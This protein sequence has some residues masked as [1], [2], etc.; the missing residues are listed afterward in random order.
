MFDKC[1]S[2]YKCTDSQ[3]CFL[4]L[5]PFF[6]HLQYITY[7]ISFIFT[8]ELKCITGSVRLKKWKNEIFWYFFVTWFDYILVCI[9]WLCT[10]VHTCR[11]ERLHNGLHYVM[12][13][14]HGY[15]NIQ[16]NKYYVNVFSISDGSVRKKQRV[17]SALLY[18]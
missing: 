8:R 6:L 7:C 13:P 4:S 3:S 2:H 11:Q 9:A 17:T 1:P 15:E 10:S 16:Y 14:L 5:N 18:I 12:S